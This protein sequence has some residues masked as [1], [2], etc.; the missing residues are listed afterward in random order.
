MD[1]TTEKQLAGRT[2]NLDRVLQMPYMKKALGVSIEKDGTIGFDNG[3]T[4]NGVDLLQR[5][6]KSMAAP[7]FNVNLIR[8]KDQREDFIDG[9]AAHNVLA[10]ESATPTGGKAAGVAAKA[11]QKNTARKAPPVSDRKSLALKGR[12]YALHLHDPRLA[13]LYDEALRIDAAKLPNCASILTRVFLE[14]ATDHLLIELKV[15]LPAL[16][17]SKQRKDWGDKGISLDEKIKHV[18][19]KIDPNGNH[20]DLRHVRQYKDAGAIHAVNALHDYI[21]NLKAKPNPREVKEI[22]ARWHPYFEHLIAALP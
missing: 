21:H 14:L 12:S 11:A 15:P 13:E 5:M 7:K 2:T 20:K 9:F 6:L 3:N 18:L 16:H 8:D 22:W 19:T 10:P 17:V 1:G 4:A